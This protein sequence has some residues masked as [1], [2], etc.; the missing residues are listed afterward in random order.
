MMPPA[1]TERLLAAKAPTMACLLRHAGERVRAQ[2]ERGRSLSRQI[3]DA[4]ALLGHALLRSTMWRRRT[5][6]AHRDG[7]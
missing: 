3:A 4:A 7:R 2:K 5:G 1:N 6:S